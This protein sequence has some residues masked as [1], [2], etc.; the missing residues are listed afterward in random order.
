MELVSRAVTELYVSVR[1]VAL[2][3]GL[4]FFLVC[5]KAQSAARDS[6]AHNTKQNAVSICV[7]KENAQRRT[8]LTQCQ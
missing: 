3:Y 5:D 7:K 8:S 4:R 1:V 2:R 6:A